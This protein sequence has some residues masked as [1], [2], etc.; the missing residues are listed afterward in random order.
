MIPEKL[1]CVGHVQKRLSTRLRNL[2]KKYKGTK[3]PISGKGKLT[4]KLINSIQNFYGMAIRSNKG[5]LYEMKKAVYAFCAVY[6]LSFYSF[7]LLAFLIMII[8]I[9]F[10]PEM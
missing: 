8:D 4:E 2:V 6:A 10:A 9:N 5:Y 3:M 1:E 7:I